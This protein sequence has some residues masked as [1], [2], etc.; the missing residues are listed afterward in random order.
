M[1]NYPIPESEFI[2]LHKAVL[3]D[4][5]LQFIANQVVHSIIMISGTEKDGTR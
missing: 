5:T 4:E 1:L 3:H 2:L